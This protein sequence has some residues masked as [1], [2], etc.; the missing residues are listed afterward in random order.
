MTQYK[1]C[2]YMAIRIKQYLSNIWSSFEDLR[3][4]WK[5]A[6]FIKKRV[7]AFFRDE[8]GGGWGGWRGEC[9][10]WNFPSWKFSL[11]IGYIYRMKIANDIFATVIKIS[12]ET[13]RHTYA[14][15]LI[16]FAYAQIAITRYYIITYYLWILWHD[17]KLN[18]TF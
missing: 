2:C 10:S 12:I 16:F 14:K 11:H 13:F 1:D 15:V 6:F 3:L 8:L 17:V 18:L 9:S 5:K 7:V 4:C